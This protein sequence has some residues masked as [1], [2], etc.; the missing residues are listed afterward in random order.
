MLW[1]CHGFCAD[2]CETAAIPAKYQNKASVMQ[3][4]KQQG[5]YL[6]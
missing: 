3:S 1:F 6:Y 2:P 5:F 4:S